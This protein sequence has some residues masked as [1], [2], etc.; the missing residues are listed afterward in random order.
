MNGSFKQRL[1]IGLGIACIF[2]CTPV[3]IYTC[4]Q[5]IKMERCLRI[6]DLDEFENRKRN[7]KIGW[8]VVIAFY[9]I[10]II[11]SASGVLD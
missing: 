10:M 9:V 3:G 6:G 7:I 4:Y 2:M 8:G 11:L 5:A 1:W